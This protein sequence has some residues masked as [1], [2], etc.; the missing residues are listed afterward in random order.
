[1]TRLKILKDEP[2]AAGRTRSAHGGNGNGTGVDLEALRARLAEAAE[3][4]Q[5]P[6]EQWR[7]LEQLAGTPEFEAFLHREFPVGASEW[8]GG[9]VSRR[10]F[11]Q[12]MGAAAAL[13]GTAACTS[14]PSE[15]IVPYVDMPE[16]IVPGKAL[17]FAST[18][19]LAGY[20]RGVLVESHMGRPTK[21][22]GNPSHPASLGATDVFAQAS[23]LDLYDPNRLETVRHL[24]RV[25][26]WSDFT[27]GL[28]AE[29]GAQEGI[30]GQG[31]RILT[32]AVSSPT[33][34]AQIER[35]LQRFPQARWHVWEPAAAHGAREGV[36]RAR[37][38]DGEAVYDLSDADVV[39]TLDSDFLVTGP[40]ALSYARQFTARRRTWHGA[41]AM[42]R[43]GEGGVPA[44]T[45]L[46]APHAPPSLGAARVEGEHRQPLRLYCVEST[47]TNTSTLADHRLPLAP[48]EVLR[49]ARALAAELGVGGGRRAR[50]FSRPRA[51]RW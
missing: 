50:R 48:S 29:L 36:R 1:M 51:A 35:V 30:G 40:G 11:L 22:E 47:P 20:G 19:T 38:A 44:D 25:S 32:G 39:L 8:Q 15:K 43:P 21:I 34:V 6:R 37:G 5:V 12:V 13:G 28:A 27:G 24:G 41:E 4:G 10:R 23:V 42:T 46:Q 17:Y 14:Q 2:A 7:S 33:L 31:L 49:F 3:S 16:G 18:H 45:G 26:T 9:E